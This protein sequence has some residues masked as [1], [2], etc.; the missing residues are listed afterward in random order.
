MGEALVGGS[1]GKAADEP[2]KEACAVVSEFNFYGD[3]LANDVL[4]GN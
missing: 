2:V 4:E 3:V 1:L